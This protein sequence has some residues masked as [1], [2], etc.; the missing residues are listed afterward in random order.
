[1]NYN[2]G[3]IVF[4][5]IGSE[6]GVAKISRVFKSGAQNDYA[7]DLLINNEQKI[8]S[9][10]IPKD[11]TIIHSVPDVEADNYLSL[12]NRLE[13]DI[14]SQKE[15]KVG[16]WSEFKIQKEAEEQQQQQSRRR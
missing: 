8:K 14:I 9:I 15:E 2:S 10:L 12:F 3:N 13:S 4:V 16:R 7:A 1:M 11:G 5:K 6:R